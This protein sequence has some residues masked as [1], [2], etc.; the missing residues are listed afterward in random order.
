MTFKERELL[1]L[2]ARAVIEA[3]NGMTYIQ[4]IQELCFA[5][6]DDKEAE[7]AERS[8]EIAESEKEY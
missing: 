7:A 6:R 4:Q 8:G 2:L 5:I 1:L 3:P